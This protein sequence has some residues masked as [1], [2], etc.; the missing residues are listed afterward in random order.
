MMFLM[1]FGIMCITVRVLSG[2]VF[3]TT[4]L[5]FLNLVST[6]GYFFRYEFKTRLVLTFFVHQKIHEMR[7]FIAALCAIAMFTTCIIAV[8]AAVATFEWVAN[9][10]L[11]FRVA[12]SSD[13]PLLVGGI[14]GGV[15]GLVVAIKHIDTVIKG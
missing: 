14:V 4:S 5:P 8:I 2:G 6:P 13:M 15:I 12:M 3:T 1:L 7:I 9:P 11:T 10:N